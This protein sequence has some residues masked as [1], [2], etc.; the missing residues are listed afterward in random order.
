MEYDQRVIIRFL[1]NEGIDAHEIIYRLQAQFSEQADALG[2]VRF[3]IAD[4]RPGRRD[5]H[6]EIRT[7][8][9]L[10]DDFDAKG[11]AIL[12]KFPLESARSTAEIV[13]VAHSTVLLHL[14]DFIGFRPFHSHWVSHIMT[15]H[16]RE[17]ERTMPKRCCLFASCR[18]S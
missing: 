1:W 3:W 5:L 15:H 12:D 16:L 13:N 18:T 17:N 6:D 10:L 7:G 8:R 11:L 2:T 4:V 9:L 14:H